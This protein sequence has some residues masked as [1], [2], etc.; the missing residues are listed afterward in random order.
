MHSFP[1]SPKYKHFLIELRAA[2]EAAGVTQEALAARLQV[3][4]T[5]ISKSETGARRLDVIELQAWLA[6]LDLSL[7]VFVADL[8]ARLVRHVPIPSARRPRRESSG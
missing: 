7:G 5:L 4:Q 1:N 6:A 2:R 3:H 8:E